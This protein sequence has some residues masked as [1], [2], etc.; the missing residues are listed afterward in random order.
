MGCL[1][2]L[3][4]ISEKK[5]LR[6]PR[7]PQ[8]LR[9]QF[10][11][12]CRPLPELQQLPHAAPGET[13]GQPGCPN[14]KAASC[15]HFPRASWDSGLGLHCLVV[16]LCWLGGGGFHSLWSGEP[17]PCPGT[18]T[19]HGTERAP[20]KRGKGT[21]AHCPVLTSCTH[22]GPWSFSRHSQP[23]TG[24]CLVHCSPQVPRMAQCHVCYRK[25][26]EPG[27]GSIGAG[28]KEASH[29]IL[30]VLEHREGLWRAR[31]R[32]QG[33]SQAGGRQEELWSLSASL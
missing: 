13:A 14:C 26:Q 25:S 4:P 28:G 22:H 19:Q 11:V 24:P 23:P 16:P 9:C 15:S 31:D 20:G 12:L 33:T 17:W 2:A 27:G 18:R 21:L 10:H 6:G 8:N 3:P 32:H 29:W 30:W 5:T 7:H 1:R